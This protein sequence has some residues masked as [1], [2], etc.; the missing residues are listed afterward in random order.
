MLASTMQFPNTPRPPGRHTSTPDT[1][2]T[3]ADAPTSTP[4]AR[5]NNPHPTTPTPQPPRKKGDTSRDRERGPVPSGPNSAPTPPP[6]AH[7]HPGTTKGTQGGP[8]GTRPRPPC[9]AR[10]GNTRRKSGE[11]SVVFP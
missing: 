11:L 9:R 7:Q 10:H 6:R 5:D 8:A 4:T 3:R 1:R 2:N